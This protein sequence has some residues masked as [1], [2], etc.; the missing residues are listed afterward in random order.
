MTGA[1][2]MS[3]GFVSGF[4][5]CVC[6]V[7]LAF[8]NEAASRGSLTKG[9]V[10]NVQKFGAK[11]DG[12]TDDTLAIQSVVNKA[13]DGSCIYFPPGV[14]LVAVEDPKGIVVQKRSRLRFLGEGPASVIKVPPEKGRSWMRFYDCEDIEIT[15]LSFDK[16]GSTRFG[17][18]AFYSSRRI[19]I[20]KNRF[21][22]SNPQPSD[23]Y[24]RYAIVFGIAPKVSEDIWISENLIEHLQV[25]IDKA[26]RVHIINNRSINP[27]YTLAFGWASGTVRAICE[28]WQIIGNLVIDPPIYGIGIALD[29]HRNDSVIRNVT[30]ANNLIVYRDK[31]LYSGRAIM[32]GSRPEERVVAK[33]VTWEN[34]AIVNN[35]VVYEPSF[36]PV[37]NLW[38]PAI[39]V[40]ASGEKERMA[41]VRISGNIVNGNGKLK[42]WG[43]EIAYATDCII[44]DNAVYGS[45]GG[46]LMRYLSRSLIQGNR[47]TDVEGD[48]YALVHSK[49]NNVFVSNFVFGIIGG[50]AF[51]LSG[52][53]PSDRLLKG[54]DGK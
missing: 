2:Q 38:R 7:A 53:H 43:I 21:F 23:G 45:Q 41:K 34:I 54:S 13:P 49:G 19:R 42:S 5:F 12:K 14:Y 48:A 20:H 4:C 39:Q 30:I 35:Q 16:N 3:A 36:E 22:D 24:D 47:V 28:D 40:T 46:I 27:E 17:G 52:A 51:N 15:R 10:F 50:S 37:R 9:S 29:G 33:G 31:P 11:G 6:F 26:R 44:S 8:A 25:E 32:I 18:V 1:K